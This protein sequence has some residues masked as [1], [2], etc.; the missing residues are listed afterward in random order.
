MNV[1]SCGS[2]TPEPEAALAATANLGPEGGEVSAVG[3]DGTVY[4]LSVPS[5]AL[6]FET[7]ITI[8]PVSA[9]P[10]LPLTGGLVAAVEFAPD[11]LQLW[12]PATLLIEL[13]APSPADVVGFGWNGAGE[14]FH[15]ALATPEGSTLRLDVTHFSGA[16]AAI[17]APENFAALQAL[18]PGS[19]EQQYLNQMPAV[20]EVDPLVWVAWL[21]AWF[22]GGVR[23]LLEGAMA[24]DEA[25][26]AGVDAFVAWKA[27]AESTVA[28]FLGVDPN[29]LLGLDG[30]ALANRIDEGLSLAAPALREGVIRNDVECIVE[31]DLAY[32]EAALRWQGIAASLGLATEAN[33]LDLGTI[34]QDFCVE[35]VYETITYPESPQ[36]GAP[37]TLI[38]S[39]G[40]SI[41][42][43]PTQFDQQLTSAI[44][45]TGTVEGP[46]FLII[47]SGESIVR[48]YTPTGEQEL[49]LHLDT[50][51][52]TPD[53]YP[54]LDGKICQ[55]AF[56]VRGF[57]ITP[58]EA[59]LEPGE[60]LDFDA[61]LYGEPHPSVTW[62]ATG[63]TITQ[64]GVYTA[65][66]EAGA[67]TVTA[68]SN[69]SGLT[70]SAAVTI[71]PG[72]GPL[73]FE[74]ISFGGQAVA[75]STNCELPVPDLARDPADSASYPTFSLSASQGGA[76]GQ[77]ALDVDVNEITGVVTITGS[78]GG[79]GSSGPCPPEAFFSNTTGQGNGS[80]DFQ[81]DFDPGETPYAFDI[82]GSVS[83]SGEYDVWLQF[84][85][86]RPSANS[87]A[88]RIT[89]T[90]IVGEPSCPGGSALSGSGP[91]PAGVWRLNVNAPAQAGP[92][93]TASSTS[94][95]FTLTLAPQ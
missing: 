17:V 84:F 28:W 26:L 73:F 91:L 43:G 60:E 71:G 15:L 70:E 81:F 86:E 6:L 11:G 41:D 38:A 7:A 79:S 34:M 55:P 87:A 31:E 85:P 25:L 3:G 83:G 10:D 37:G 1:L 35:V 24:S 88:C 13:P 29:F 27:A 2:I 39:A 93:F 51:L 76:S 68:T 92:I 40:Y 74:M 82:T 16:G 18:P 47:A 5:G 58:E 49:A 9:I 75:G 78:G 56:V 12:Q 42:A 90:G 50:C 33:D 63:G 32:A 69:F 54:V 80:L 72:A 20:S 4:R 66:D 46:S 67:F 36:A 48:D 52:S 94:Y 23:P 21:S 95:D 19:V 77:A 59:M 62:T 64:A 65:G 61:L 45:P 30:F 44:E 22:D 57:E 89:E 8:T 53:D 14:D